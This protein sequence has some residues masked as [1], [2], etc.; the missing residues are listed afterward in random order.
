MEQE[1]ITI[2]EPDNLI[3]FGYRKQFSDEA[4]VWLKKHY[5]KY[6]INDF[7]DHLKVK[8]MIKSLEKY[9]CFTSGFSCTLTVKNEDEE[10][11]PIS[12]LRLSMM[13]LSCT[14][15]HCLDTLGLY[16]LRIV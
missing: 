11:A 9:F 13:H 7:E 12:D 2:D 5:A 3:N 10:V 4:N 8:E 6:N 16:H 15:E 1:I 14:E